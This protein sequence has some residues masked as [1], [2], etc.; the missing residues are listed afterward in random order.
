MNYRS[1]ECPAAPIS[2]ATT[3]CG[4]HR[5]SRAQESRGFALRPNNVRKHGDGGL[6]RAA[7]TPGRVRIHVLTERRGSPEG[8]GGQWE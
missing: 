1:F 4:M 8:V 3:D 6:Y 2:Q 5:A 7:A